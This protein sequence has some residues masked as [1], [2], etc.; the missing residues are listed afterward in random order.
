MA[1]PLPHLSGGPGLVSR[2]IEV[3]SG[4]AT[5]SPPGTL[6]PRTGSEVADGLQRGERETAKDTPPQHAGPAKTMP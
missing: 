6:Y 5:F 1:S 4:S 3:L 2:R